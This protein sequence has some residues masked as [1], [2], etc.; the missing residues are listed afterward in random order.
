MQPEDI[1]LK[2]FLANE[3]SDYAADLILGGGER[4]CLAAR[5]LAQLFKK[6]TAQ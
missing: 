2:A 1:L 3:Q 6:N 5:I 4:Q